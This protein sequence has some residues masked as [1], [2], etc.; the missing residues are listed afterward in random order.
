MRLHHVT[1]RRHV[2]SITETGFEDS[3]WT[4]TGVFLSPPGALWVAGGMDE[5]NF[6]LLEPYHV[7][8]AFDVPADVAAQYAVMEKTPMLDEEPD[9]VPE[10]LDDDP[11]EKW[12]TT[13]PGWVIFE[14][15]IPAAVANLYC[16][17]PVHWTGDPPLSAA[18]LALIEARRKPPTTES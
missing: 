18:Q 10:N 16:A 8:F 5:L 12:D 6:D 9:E 15:C 14:Y 7:V 11:P 2:A 17:G 1:H 3:R 4:V 13:A